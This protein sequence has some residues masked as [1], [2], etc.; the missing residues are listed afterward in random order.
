MQRC[1]VHKLLTRSVA[2]TAYSHHGFPI[3]CTA[4]DVGRPSP[5][6]SLLAH[7]V[8]R[9]QPPLRTSRACVSSVAVSVRSAIMLK[10]AAE[11]CTGCR[12]KSAVIRPAAAAE[13]LYG[14]VCVLV[15]RPD[16]VASSS[17][18]TTLCPAR[19]VCRARPGCLGA[20][21]VYR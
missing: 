5:S 3:D 18:H 1:I 19:L 4:A 7:M 13:A 11:C 14:T 9:G 2:A 10:M 20:C 12:H 15:S 6:S 21:R 8:R 17:F 16:S